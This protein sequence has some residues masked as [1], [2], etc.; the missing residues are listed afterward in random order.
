MFGSMYLDKN[1]HPLYIGKSEFIAD[2]DGTTE[3]V[4][5]PSSGTF[6]EKKFLRLTSELGNFRYG[7][8]SAPTV[9]GSNGVLVTEGV[10]ELT[11]VDAGEKLTIHGS[12]VN[13]CELK[14]KQAAGV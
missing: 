10:V 7:I 13:V 9:D 2:L 8:G 6:S 3:A 14:G 1:G 12:I 11:E 4:S 5:Y